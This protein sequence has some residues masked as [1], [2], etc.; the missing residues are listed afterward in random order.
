MVRYWLSL[1]VFGVGFAFAIITVGGT[2]STFLVYLNLPSFILVGLIP[3]C[4]A[5]TIFGP[6]NMTSAFSVLRK[7]ET[8]KEKLQEAYDFFKAFGKMAWIMGIIGVITGIVTMLVNLE[9]TAA[10]GPNLALSLISI[11]YSGI[12]NIVLVIP[13]MVLIKQKLK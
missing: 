4:I 6:R 8:D 3:F 5:G 1:L 11:L 12:I 9:D 13:F 10:I 7:K 2:G